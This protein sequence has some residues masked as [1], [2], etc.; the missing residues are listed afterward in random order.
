MTAPPD[1]Y[2][3][4]QDIAPQPPFRAVFDRDYLLHAASGALD[5]RIGANRWLLPRSFAAWVPAGT[6]FEVVIHRPVQSCSILTVP[7][8]ASAF[9]DHPVTF[10]MS[11]LTRAMA[12]HCRHWG[13]SDPQPAHARRFFQALL[14]CCADLVGASVDVTRPGSTDPGLSRALTHMESHLAEPLNAG[15][16]AQAAGIS[17][18]T[19]HRRFAQ[20]LGASWGETLTRLRMIR[21]LELLG[22]GNTKIVTIAADCGYASQSAFT[23]AFRQFAGTSP[24]SYRQGIR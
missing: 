23:R 12:S 10:Q 8:F 2:C 22:D 5:L 15:L 4:F 18:R 6:A 16:T 11:A 21:A 19:M 17:E 20:E 7:R 1:A 14:D 13:P 24:A 9:P 3:F